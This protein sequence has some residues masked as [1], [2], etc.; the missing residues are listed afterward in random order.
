M[1][2]EVNPRENYAR[3]ITRMA[4]YAGGSAVLDDDDDTI[5]AKITHLQTTYN[6]FVTSHNKVLAVSGKQAIDLQHE[7]FAPIEDSF[8]STM[9]RLKKFARLARIRDNESGRAA[10]PGNDSSIEH[11]GRNAGS[12]V[13]RKIQLPNFSTGY[14][15][16]QSFLDLYT[17]LVH[18]DQARPP[19]EKFHLCLQL[20]G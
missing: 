8:L 15:E 18:A 13:L 20:A 14:I 3:T 17:V 7:L 1:S 4:K 12:S 19:V 2:E 5:D 16:W 11:P 6:N 9:G 10:P